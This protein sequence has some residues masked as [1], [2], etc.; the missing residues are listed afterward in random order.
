[1]DQ[2]ARDHVAS[3]ASVPAVA[4][5]YAERLDDSVKID[6][7]EGHHLQRVRRIRAGETMTIADGYG[8]WRVYEVA[9]VDAGS[10]SLRARTE[11][12]HERPLEPALTVACAL[13]KGDRPEL[14]VQKLTELGVDQI[15][16]VEA[17]RSVVHWNET[18]AQAALE[19]LGRVAREAGAQSRRARLPNIDGPIRPRDLTA[20]P[21]LV[22]AD[23]TGV[24]ADA[25]PLPAAAPGAHAEWWV[26]IGPEGGFTHQELEGFGD[27]HRMALGPY[28]LR[29]DTA[30]IAAAAALAGRRHRSAG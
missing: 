11:L 30:A 10:L 2:P 4:H 26:A 12:Q 7:D 19:R 18:R 3:P 25:L 5:A 8:R 15:V 13:T 29:A 1:M 14:V 9:D 28:G 27:A 21:G 24:T 20:F 17:E 16:F 6:G 22:V 23:A